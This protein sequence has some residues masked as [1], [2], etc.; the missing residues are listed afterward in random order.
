MAS[1]NQNND[2]I[3]YAKND[4]VGTEEA[5]KIWLRLNDHLQKF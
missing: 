2:Y 1:S 3:F 4:G 5:E